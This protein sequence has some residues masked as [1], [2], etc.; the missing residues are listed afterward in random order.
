M[1]ASEPGCDDV[2]LAHAMHTVWLAAANWPAAHGV[3]TS[4]LDCE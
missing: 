1:H 4:E 2:P 3:Q